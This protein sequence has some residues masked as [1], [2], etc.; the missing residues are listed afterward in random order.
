MKHQGLVNIVK[1]IK[2]ISLV[3]IDYYLYN[4]SH[5]KYRISAKPPAARYL[6]IVFG[7]QMLPTH[8]QVPSIKETNCRA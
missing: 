7:M 3:H 4:L 5:E 2:S 6:D 1:Q 8:I